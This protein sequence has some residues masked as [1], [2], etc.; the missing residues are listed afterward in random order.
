MSDKPKKYV[1][2]NRRAP[3]KA[4]EPETA[5]LKD[6]KSRFATPVK[7][8]YGYVSRGELNELQ[9][10]E[11]ARK[12]YFDDIQRLDRAKPNRILDSL[13]KLREAILHLEADEFTKEVY[14]FS[15]K[16]S[17]SQGTYQ[18]YI[19]CGQYLLRHKLLLTTE[20]ILKIAKVIILHV[21]HCNHDN[22]R[23]M[24]LFFEYYTAL[25]PLY[26]VLESWI[27]EDYNTWNNLFRAEKDEGCSRVMSLGLPKMM[28][29]MARCLTLLYFTMGVEDMSKLLGER[30]VSQFI[31]DWKTGWTVE[32]GIVTIRR[33]K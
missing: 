33:R 16:F 1:P 10:D 30:L 2:P 29:H 27:L 24:L 25:D 15:F 17:V 6:R 12:A 19:P 13:R 11:N 18:T 22:G 28:S 4:P 31:D 7:D 8:E 21:S 5:K 3:K 23:A 14:M 32:N 26:L 20:E 9:T